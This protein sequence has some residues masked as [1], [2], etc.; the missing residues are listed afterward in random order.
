MKLTRNPQMNNKQWS[1]FCNI[2]G[3][4]TDQIFEKINSYD[5]VVAGELVV[6]IRIKPCVDEDH[7]R[8]G[9][10]YTSKEEG[11]VPLSVDKPLED[12]A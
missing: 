10:I 3:L 1:D 2:Q 8:R 11:F 9:Q 4:K 6:Y 12:Y 7:P 5:Q